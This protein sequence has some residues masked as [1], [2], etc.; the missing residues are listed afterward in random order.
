LKPKDTLFN[1]LPT[2]FQTDCA[3]KK[4]GHLIDSQQMLA[5]AKDWEMPHIE[6]SKNPYE[7]DMER[8]LK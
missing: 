5:K 8:F 3:S 1:T 7:E 6:Q 2:Y 4:L